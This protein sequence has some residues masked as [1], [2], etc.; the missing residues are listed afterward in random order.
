MIF[1]DN[2]RRAP[3]AEWKK[4]D[5]RRDGTYWIIA[6]FQPEAKESLPWVLKV[7]A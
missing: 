6:V 4:K 2:E 5:S 3:N 7:G 1:E